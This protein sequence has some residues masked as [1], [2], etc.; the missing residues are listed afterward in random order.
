MG[1]PPASLL[2]NGWQFSHLVWHE[3]GHSGRASGSVQGGA[4]RPLRGSK[5]WELLIVQ[6]QQ[7]QR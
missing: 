4:P 2:E 6:A 3:S 7:E 5:S 1:V